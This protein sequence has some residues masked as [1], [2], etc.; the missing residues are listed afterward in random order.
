VASRVEGAWE[1]ARPFLA[2]G[3]PEV[4][5]SLW[6][7]DDEVGRLFFVAFHGA[8]LAE[9]DPLLALHRTQV[10]MLHDPDAS[11][12]HPATWAGVVCVGGLDPRA[13]GRLAPDASRRS[14]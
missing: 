6:D 2:S 10:A 3:V 4:V 1:L 14:F 5:A 9:G 7:V 11:L 13:L 8:L 12:A